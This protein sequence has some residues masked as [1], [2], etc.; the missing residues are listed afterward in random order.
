MHNPRS[1]VVPVETPK[2]ASEWRN[3]DGPDIALPDL[4]NK[5][6][7]SGVDILDP[8]L[9][10]PVTLRREIDDVPR[11]GQETRSRIWKVADLL[12]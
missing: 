5:R 7:Q 12:A 10:L 9:A 1:N 2:P 11:P 8:A 3:G 6:R 4:L